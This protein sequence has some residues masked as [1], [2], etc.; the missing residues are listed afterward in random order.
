MKDV[1]CPFNLE[2]LIE[3]ELG[4]PRMA[5]ARIPQGEG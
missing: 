1:N 3:K 4:T 2:A 5:A